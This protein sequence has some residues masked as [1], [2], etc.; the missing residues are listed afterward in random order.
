MFN[1]NGMNQIN[2]SREHV[3]DAI[4]KHYQSQITHLIDNELFGDADALFL[5]Y[6]VGGEEPK[7]WTF[8]ELCSEE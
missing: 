7:E 3:I 1:L 2:A 6:V 4:E 5:E 8:V